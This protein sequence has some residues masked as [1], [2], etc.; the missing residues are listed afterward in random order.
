[1]S[2]NIYMY[3]SLWNKCASE[4]LSSWDGEEKGHEHS[5]GSWLS[6]GWHEACQ[7]PDLTKTALNSSISFKSTHATLASVNNVHCHF[8]THSL[9]VVNRLPDIIIH[10][11]T[12]V[13]HWN[14]FVF[15]TDL[16]CVLLFNH[17]ETCSWP[18][19]KIKFSKTKSCCFFF[20]TVKWSVFHLC[21]SQP[22]QERWTTMNADYYS[23]CSPDCA[24]SSARCPTAPLKYSQLRT[25]STR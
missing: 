17:L 7:N 12:Q 3:F 4:T 22:S 14:S 25:L 24:Q 13:K 1:M 16:S 20:P 19:F 18:I 6:N 15:N 9:L 11:K 10:N 2:P 21:V 23:V 5:T 8:Q